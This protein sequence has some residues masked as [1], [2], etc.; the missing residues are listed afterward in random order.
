MSKKGGLAF[1]N[2]KS[3]H[4]Q[5]FKNI[6]IVWEAEEK[7]RE[8]ARRLAQ[9]K[10]EK[11][12]ERQV[13]ELRRLQAQSGLITCAHCSRFCSR[14]VVCHLRS[15]SGRSFFRSVA[16]ALMLCLSAL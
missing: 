11:D 15:P 16:C 8:E 1:L 12:E 2:K 6:K 3:W 4:T 14:L 9:L 5:S 10:K 13:E 7:A